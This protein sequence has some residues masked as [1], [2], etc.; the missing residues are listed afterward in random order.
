[1]P[2]FANSRY[3]FN[4]NFYKYN[5]IIEALFVDPKIYDFWRNYR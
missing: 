2:V 5:I 4:S 1:M 3:S